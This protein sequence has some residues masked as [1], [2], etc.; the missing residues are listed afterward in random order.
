MKRYMIQLDSILS[1]IELESK[2]DQ[3]TRMVVVDDG[4]EGSFT[5]WY[6]EPNKIL[7]SKNLSAM[8]VVS[9]WFYSLAITF[10]DG[11]FK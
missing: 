9:W 2:R 1:N 6:T 4:R 8:S 11:Y 5:K 7:N 3:S 10:H